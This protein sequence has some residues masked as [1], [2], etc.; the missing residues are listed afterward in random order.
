MA[1]SPADVRAIVERACARPD[2]LDACA[3]RDLGAV[4]AALGSSGLTQGRISALTGIQQGRVSEYA[5][6]KRKPTASST[7][8]AFADGLGLTPA[9]RRAL[10]LAPG[11]SLAVAGETGP[12]IDASYPDG[13]AQ[14][15]EKVSALWRVD[16]ADSTSVQRGRVDPRAWGDASLRWLVGPGRATDDRPAGGARIGLA[17]VGRFRS[18]VDLFAD[19]DNRFGG[20]HARE[21]LIQYLN[22][23]ATRILRGNYTADVGRGLFSAVGE[24]TL[25]A[26][27]MTYDAVP[28]SALAQGTS[29]RRSRL[30]K[31]ETTGSSERAFLTR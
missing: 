7:F 8:E 10:G 21:A 9:A 25:L 27:W 5:T 23:D 29:C 3:R 15:V 31:P 18:T 22:T 17:D 12:D 1:V 4:I 11:S 2:V 13:A 20:G 24:A 16:L 26:A 19:L 6:G 28:T 14:A 30:P